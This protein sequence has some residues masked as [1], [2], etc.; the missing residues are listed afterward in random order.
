MDVKVLEG[1]GKKGFLVALVE[2]DEIRKFYNK[3]LIKRKVVLGNEESN[4]F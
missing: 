2:G 1:F 3:R 4:K